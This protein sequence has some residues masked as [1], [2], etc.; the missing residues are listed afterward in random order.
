MNNMKDIIADIIKKELLRQ[1]PLYGKTFC[2]LGSSVTYGID[3][4]SF[5]DFIREK[6][7]C[8]CIKEAVPGTTLSYTDEESYIPRMLRKLD[9]NM[10][11]DHFLCQLS[12]NDTGRNIPLGRISPSYELDSFD[13]ATITG[14]MEYIICYAMKTFKCP[15]SFYTGTRYDCQEY[16]SMVERLFELQKKWSIGI[17]DLWNQSGMSNMLPEVLEKYM[18]DP[19]HPNLLAYEKWWAPII[20]DHLRKYAY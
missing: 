10:K 6:N 5:V 1:N 13:T 2:F 4:I 11:L 16:A 17:V 20:E 18:L 12:T 7:G 15:V 19:I 14:A 9:K 3:N 8:N